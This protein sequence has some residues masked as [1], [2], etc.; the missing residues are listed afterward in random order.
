MLMLRLL[1]LVLPP[2]QRHP[3]NRSIPPAQKYMQPGQA[4]PPRP[5]H[6]PCT[7]TQPGSR[8]SPPIHIGHV[9]QEEALQY[10]QSL[11]VA[12]RMAQ[13]CVG[14]VGGA[15]LLLER[16]AG[17]AKAGMAFPGG[18]Q[19][20]RLGLWRGAMSAGPWELRAA[21]HGARTQLESGP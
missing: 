10:L 16:C 17:M 15:L 20:Q 1:R 21:V 4:S 12:G 18:A 6:P 14:L 5:S 8:A 9:T 13:D 2:A 11:G 19:R 3:H 7:G